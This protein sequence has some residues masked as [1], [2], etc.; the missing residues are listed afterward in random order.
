MAASAMS[1][2]PLTITAAVLNLVGVGIRSRSISRWCSRRVA[3]IL[4]WPPGQAVHIAARR[5]SPQELLARRVA[6]P[7]LVL[8]RGPAAQDAELDPGVRMVQRPEDVGGAPLT[9]P[10][11][12]RPRAETANHGELVA[13][14]LDLDSLPQ[15][16]DLRLDRRGIADD[17]KQPRRSFLEAPGISRVQP[18]SA[19]GIGLVQDLLEPSMLIDGSIIALSA[20]STVPNRPQ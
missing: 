16:P 11:S 7:A 15:L 8:G 1:N 14:V 9:E 6:N 17:L 19:L 4:Q 3:V 10:P 5:A 18:Q 20:Q 2:P 13:V 12:Q